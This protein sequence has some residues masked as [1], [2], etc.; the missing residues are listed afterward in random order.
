MGFVADV[1]CV[2]LKTRLVNFTNDQFTVFAGLFSPYE[3]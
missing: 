2:L 1:P 3:R